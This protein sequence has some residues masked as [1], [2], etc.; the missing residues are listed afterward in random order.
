VAARGARSSSTA[1]GVSACSCRSTKT[2][3]C[4]NLASLC[5]CK[6]L[7]IWVGSMAATCGLTFVGAAVTSIGYKRSPRSWSAG[8]PPSSCQTGTRRGGLVV[9][10]DAFT[11]VHRAPIILAAAR[12]NIPVVFGTSVFA[13][14][15]GLLSYGPDRVDIWRRAA[16]YVDRILRG[17]KPGDLPVQFPVKYEMIGTS[18]PP[19]RSV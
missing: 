9:N 11:I 12:N 6:R 3:P 7:R 8:N 18:R 10:S 15:D 2:I 13:R 1:C 14:E 19:S 16:T 17:E 5:S 4:R